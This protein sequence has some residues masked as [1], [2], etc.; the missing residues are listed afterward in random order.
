MRA[1]SER[2]LPSAIKLHTQLYSSPR[3]RQTIPVPTGRLRFL[4]AKALVELFEGGGDVSLAGQ[5]NPTFEIGVYV[6]LCSLFS[7]LNRTTALGGAYAVPA[8]SWQQLTGLVWV[9]L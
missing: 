3:R 6:I 7:D 5:A 8:F 1:Q 9:H 4:L 2:S